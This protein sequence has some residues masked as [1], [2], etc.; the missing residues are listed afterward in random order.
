MIVCDNVGDYFF[1]N[2]Y[3]WFEYEVEVVRVV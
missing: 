2:V 1:G 3:V